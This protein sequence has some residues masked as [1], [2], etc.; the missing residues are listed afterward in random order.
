MYDNT[1]ALCVSLAGG[2]PFWVSKIPGMVVRSNNAPW[3][4]QMQRFVSDMIT[5]ARPLLAS[6]GGPIIVAQV[7][8]EFHWQDAKYVEWCGELAEKMQAGIPWI[9][10]NGESARNT[11]N[12]CNGNDCAQYAET[13]GVNHSGQPLAWT[14]NEGWYQA[15]NTKSLTDQNNRPASEMAYVVMKWIARGGAYHNYYMWYGGN[16]FGRKAA[17]SCITTMYA[18][19]VNL[20]S[21]GLANEPKN[22]HLQ[23]LHVQLGLMNPLLMD[24]SGQANKQ[25]YV[26]AYDPKTGQ[27][28]VSKN[29]FVFVYRSN[30]HGSLYFLENSEKSYALV[31][32]MNNHYGLAGLSSLLLDDRGST[33]YNSSEVQTRGIPTQ[34]VMVP[35]HTKFNW[36]V[37]WEAPHMTPGYRVTEGGPS[38]QLNATNDLTDFLYYQTWLPVMANG[39]ITIPTTD[40]NAFQVFLDGAWQADFVSCNHGPVTKKSYSFG[41]S[42]YTNF[43]QTLTI[44]STSLGVTTHTAPGDHDMKGIV[45]DVTFGNQSMLDWQLHVGLIGEEKK[46]FTKEGMGNVEWDT[47]WKTYRSFKL[48]WYRATFDGVTV[49][50][51]SSLL[52]D[53]NGMTRGVIYINGFNL[54][55]YWMTKVEGEY[56]QRYYYL[57]PSLL[58]PKDNL[59]VVFEEEGAPAAESVQLLL[60]SM[61]VPPQ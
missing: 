53:M 46:V 60:S 58:L 21:D 17:G 13:H 19:G 41:V 10:C 7:E 39:T 42:G 29:Q 18:D 22:S 35:L 11:I 54:G 32:Y 56:V 15:W 5:L 38:E 1:F 49:P 27:F 36:N 37:W 47:D 40:S 14:E 57:P 43:T 48:T 9:M 2:I 12:T 30:K 45:G 25:Q 55:R 59:L 16:N 34:R 6:Q 23:K 51:G 8:N 61:R 28:N 20:H 50:E 3:K 4:Q 26:E 31:H 33:L 52:L 44:L 24:C